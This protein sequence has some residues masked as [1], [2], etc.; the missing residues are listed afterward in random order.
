MAVYWPLSD[1]SPGP[2]RPQPWPW[3]LNHMHMRIPIDTQQRFDTDQS[4]SIDKQEFLAMQSP[5]VLAKF[6][7][8]TILSWFDAADANGASAPAAWPYPEASA[9]AASAT[10]ASAPAAGPA[11]DVNGDARCVKCRASSGAAPPPLACCGQHCTPCPVPLHRASVWVALSP[12]VPGGAAVSQSPVS[13]VPAPY[14][15]C[16][17]RDASSADALL[18][19]PHTPP[20]QRSARSRRVLRD[21]RPQGHAQA[22]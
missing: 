17:E 7:Q 18:A 5:A 21:E 20:R 13:C 15:A 4:Q 16:S 6:S 22:A 14:R 19:P 11:A 3:P 1:P 8:E 9:P 12:A 10:A 2:K